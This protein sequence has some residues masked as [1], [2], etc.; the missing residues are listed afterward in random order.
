MLLAEESGHTV[1]A[2]LTLVAAE[3]FPGVKLRPV[4]GTDAPNGV[5][6]CYKEMRLLLQS[7]V[8]VCYKGSTEASATIRDDRCYR[9]WRRL[10]QAATA[11]CY[12]RRPLLQTTGWQRWLLQTV[13]AVATNWVLPCY[14]EAV[15]S[16]RCCK[17]VPM[18]CKEA[19]EA[20]GGGRRCWFYKGPPQTTAAVATNQMMRCCTEAG[21]AVSGATT[22]RR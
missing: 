13:A 12:T 3:E 6:I 9:G 22:C 17:R 8:D 10:L 18:C 1:A 11:M 2:S 16:G 14:K 15:G 19:G 20:V 4:T 7:S 5:A 21:E